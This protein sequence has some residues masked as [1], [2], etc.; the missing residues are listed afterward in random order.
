MLFYLFI[1]DGGSE[2]S[3][4]VCDNNFCLYKSKKSFYFSCKFVSNTELYTVS[5]LKN[6]YSC[7]LQAREDKTPVKRNMLFYHLGLLLVLCGDVEVHPRPLTETQ[8]GIKVFCQSKGLKIFHQNIRGLQGTFDEL[9]NIILLCKNIGVFCINEPFVHGDKSQNFN[10]L[11]YTLLQK[12]RKN[13]LGGGVGVC[14][15]SELNFVER[16]VLPG[17]NIE[18]IFI[19][20]KQ[21]KQAKSIIAATVCKPPESSKHLPKHFLQSLTEKLKKSAMKK[22]NQ[23]SRET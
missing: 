5:V 22:P 11:G 16:E 9:K 4:G 15:R 1:Q 17:D 20:I 21:A 8:Q 3:H 10:I 18:A 6:V 14:I 7:S 13:G 2:G 12:R 23:L 19:E